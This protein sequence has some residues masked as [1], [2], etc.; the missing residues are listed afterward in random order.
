MNR[1]A[2]IRMKVALGKYRADP[3]AERDL[4][5]LLAVIDLMGREI[6]ALSLA[7][8]DPDNEVAP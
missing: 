2:R 1:L 5:H 8:L 7:N 6:E 4:T 3:E